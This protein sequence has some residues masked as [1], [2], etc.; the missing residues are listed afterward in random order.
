MRRVV[1]LCG[2]AVFVVVGMQISFAK[3]FSVAATQAAPSAADPP[4]QSSPAPAA[5][6]GSPSATGA[7]PADT[8]APR[9]TLYMPDGQLASHAVRVYVN[10]DIPSTAK[11][12]LHL[13]GSNA[14]TEAASTDS[15][16]WPPRLVAPGQEWRQPSVDGEGPEITGRGTLL[17]FDLKP[18]TF[19]YKAMRRVM[20]V[21]SWNEAGINRMAVGQREVNVG[22]IVLA[23]AWTGMVVGAMLLIVIVLAWRRGGSPMLLLTGVDGHLSLAQAQIAC[24]TVAVG[25]VVLVY[26]FIRLAIP[27]IPEA[28]L[29]LM[30][31]SLTTG[32][33]AFFRDAQKQQAAVAAGASPVTRTWH[34][35]DLVRSFETG[36]EPQLSLA[37]AQMLFWTVLL[38]VLFVTKSILDGAIW[39]VP[40]PLVALLGFSQ[41]GYLAPKLATQP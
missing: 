8:Q 19:N 5:A 41:A 17:L 13:Y 9:L 31:A 3:T 10:H 18:L 4:D 32:G 33:L 6:Q 28:L 12:T 34:W 23:A 16:D 21:L 25:S 2:A 39:N 15:A 38:I 7:P 37:K 1:F 29:V 30:G 35:S 24:W 26:G 27:E 36:Q 14:L 20:P 22:N 40:W 11:P